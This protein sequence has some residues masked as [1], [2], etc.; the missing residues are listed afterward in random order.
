[1]PFGCDR[2]L[3]RRGSLGSNRGQNAVA[4]GGRRVAFEM[5][6]D[7]IPRCAP[8][9]GGLGYGDSWDRAEGVCEDTGDLFWRLIGMRHARFVAL[10]T[11][12]VVGLILPLA[13]CKGQMANIRL[14]KAQEMLF[15]GI[16]DPGCL[17]K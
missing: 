14:K 15:W 7:A 16:P 10:L 11:I 4:G 9:G 2:R 12:L 13:S 17:G 3:R 1:M 6:R 8:V 5:S